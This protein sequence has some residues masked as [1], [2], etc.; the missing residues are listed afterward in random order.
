MIFTDKPKDFSG[1]E[2]VLIEALPVKD[3]DGRL[4]G[5]V[6]AVPDGVDSDE[7][8]A[9]YVGYRYTECKAGNAYID[10]QHAM[11]WVEG[12]DNP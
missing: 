6:V 8:C 7:N 11:L 9:H 2:A 12:D 10:E 4:I 3:E 5:Y 1:N